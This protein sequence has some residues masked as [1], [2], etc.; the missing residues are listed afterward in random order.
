M[1][2]VKAHKFVNL[3]LKDKQEKKVKLLDKR[4]PWNT[5]EGFLSQVV[6]LVTEGLDNDIEWLSAIKKQ[7]PPLSNCKHPKYLRDK[8]DGKLYCMGCNE[9][10][11]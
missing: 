2:L 8:C 11:E 3:Q 10:L 9:D 7:L 5:G 6:A 1:T 4:Y